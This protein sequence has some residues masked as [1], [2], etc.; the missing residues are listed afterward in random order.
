MIEI[1]NLTKIYGDIIAVDDLSFTVND[2]E[3][4]G[5]LG[6]NGAGKSTTMNIITGYL[7][8]TSGDVL[9]DGIDISKNPM[10]VRRKIGYL[11]EQPPV[12]M[13]MR[14][15]EYLDFCAGIKGIPAKDIKK[16]VEKAMSLLKI[17]DVQKRLIKNLSKGY[18]QRV[19]F[20]QAIL[21]DPKVLILD[22]PTVGLDPNQTLEV[23]NVIRSL[24]KDRTIIFS[25]HIL[26]EVSAVC[27]RVVIIDKGK[28]KAIDTPW[29]LAH[30][31]DKHCVYSL[32]IEGDKEKAYDLLKGV[33]GVR[34]VYNVTELDARTNQFKIDVS[35]ERV[36]KSVLKKLLESEFELVEF[37]EEKTSLEDVFV[38]LTGKKK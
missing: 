4:L 34:Q 15:R 27:E 11:P 14:V 24:K 35:D 20:A 7:P 30:N 13:D 25:S 28:I 33:N 16:S 22:E 5:F 6:P 10:E 38:S 3:V 21:A 37:S 32:K 29:N 31:M 18:R 36:R 23:R 2:N 26:Q 8:A 12:Y 17:T 9:V 19:G 1:K